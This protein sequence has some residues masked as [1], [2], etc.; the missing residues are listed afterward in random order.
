M[1]TLLGAI[2]CLFLT[3]GAALAQGQTIYIP[4]PNNCPNDPC[5]PLQ[6]RAWEDQQYENKVKRPG[7]GYQ[8][9]FTDARWTCDG[10]EM[11]SALIPDIDDKIVNQTHNPNAELVYGISDAR[12][13]SRTPDKLTCHGIWRFENNAHVVRNVGVTWVWVNGPYGHA[14]FSWL[15]E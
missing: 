5:S 3:S 10:R 1:K 9:D 11:L 13:I 6:R 2:L 8:F 12:E 15:V 4:A 14:D 7:G